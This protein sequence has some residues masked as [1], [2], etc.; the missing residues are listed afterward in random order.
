MCFFGSTLSINPEA[1]PKKTIVPQIARQS[2]D[3]SKV[4]A[5]TPS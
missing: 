1:L 3:S 5:P 4:L 2:K